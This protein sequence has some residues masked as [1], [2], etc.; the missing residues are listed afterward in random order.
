MYVCIVVTSTQPKTLFPTGLQLGLR[1][2]GGLLPLCLSVP[3]AY[4]G[5]IY[6]TTVL[7][8][9][10]GIYLSTY[11]SFSF[12]VLFFF[13]FLFLFYYFIFY[14]ATVGGALGYYRDGVGS[15]KARDSYRMISYCGILCTGMYCMYRWSCAMSVDG[16]MERRL[17]NETWKEAL[18]PIF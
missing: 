3:Q 1:T 11:L 6:R 13:F 15:C 16:L 14:I 9:F 17:G 5:I 10:Y 12:R 4:R 7:L 18:L 2:F 8:C